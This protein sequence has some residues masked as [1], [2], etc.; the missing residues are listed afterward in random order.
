MSWEFTAHACRS[1]FGTI[2]RSGS[3]FTCSICRATAENS[4]FRIC[5]CGA[6]VFGPNGPRSAGLRCV[7]NPRPTPACPSH[8]LIALAPPPAHAA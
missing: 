6:N 8:V 3:A 2:L 1:C 5:G 4:P 7:E